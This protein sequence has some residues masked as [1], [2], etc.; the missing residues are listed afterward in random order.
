MFS[1]INLKDVPVHAKK[2]LGMEVELHDFSTST[3]D[4]DK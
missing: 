4:E 3:L 1:K 2:A